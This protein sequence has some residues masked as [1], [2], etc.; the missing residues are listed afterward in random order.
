MNDKSNVRYCDAR[1]YSVE[2]ESL[3]PSGEGKVA[4]QHFKVRYL[5][6]RIGRHRSHCAVCSRCRLASTARHPGHAPSGTAGIVASQALYKNWERIQEL[7][8]FCHG[9]RG[10]DES[11]ER[12]PGAWEQFRR[13]V[14]CGLRRGNRYWI[15]IQGIVSTSTFY[16]A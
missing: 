6:K 2:P 8:G 12:K 13:D 15:V 14:S 9:T 5:C 11:W 1:F 7:E 10:N 16:G 3:E 4:W